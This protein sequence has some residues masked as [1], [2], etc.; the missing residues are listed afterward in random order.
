[1]ADAKQEM[2][3][4]TEMRKKRKFKHETTEK[5]LNYEVKQ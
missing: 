1:M 2:I 5:S 4:D 3:M